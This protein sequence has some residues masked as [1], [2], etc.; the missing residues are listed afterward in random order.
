MRQ[1][2]N[3]NAMFSCKNLLIDLSWP[4]CSLD[5]YVSFPLIVLIII[6]IEHFTINLALHA[7]RMTQRSWIILNL[8][9]TCSEQYKQRGLLLSMQRKQSRLSASAS[10]FSPK[11]KSG[12]LMTRLILM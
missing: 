3:L 1:I 9:Q 10:L 8:L 12:F 11:Q 4:N 2:H 5:K 6:K 7:V